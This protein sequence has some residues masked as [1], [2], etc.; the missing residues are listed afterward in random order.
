MPKVNIGFFEISSKDAG[1]FR[2]RTELS[3]HN[4]YFYPDPIN[5]IN[6][7]KIK[8]LDI[9]SP[10]IY[11][12]INSEVL[13]ICLKLK[14]IATRS[15]GY[16]HIDMAVCHKHGIV[17]STVPTYGENTVAEHTFALILALSRNIHKAHVRTTKGDFSLSGLT[18]FDL[19]GK[20][21]GVVGT[22]KI[23]MRVHWCPLKV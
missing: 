9:I 4:L 7:A 2:R 16:D 5:S 14:L 15:T 17:V 21:L 1:F 6:H 13:K 19:K 11:S 8:K 20:I 18:G 3:S 10:F 22:G 23:G 12:K